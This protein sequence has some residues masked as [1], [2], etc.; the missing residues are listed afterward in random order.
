[1]RNDIELRGN[2]SKCQLQNGTW[3]EGVGPV[4]RY[5]VVVAL[6]V[7]RQAR[8]AAGDSIRLPGR[9]V[10]G[11]NTVFRADLFVAPDGNLILANDLGSRVPAIEIGVASVDRGWKSSLSIGNHR[12]GEQT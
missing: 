1:M 5:V 6:R 7:S 10:T 4:H 2:M 11:K 12:R 3:S 8:E 9:G